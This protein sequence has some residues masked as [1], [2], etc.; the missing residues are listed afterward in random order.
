MKIDRS[1][2]IPLGIM[3]TN[4]KVLIVFNPQAGQAKVLLPAIEL[5]AT[6][7][8]SHGWKVDLEPTQCVNDGIRIAREGAIN[9]YDII[10]AAGGD[11]TVNEVMNGLVHTNC[12]LGV[13]PAGTVNI[14]ARE[15]GLPMDIKQCAQELL[16]SQLSQIDVGRAS[17][18]VPRRG[19]LLSRVRLRK[20]SPTIVDRYFLLMGGIG[21]DAAVTASVNPQEKKYLGAIAYIKRAIQIA[22]GYQG[23]HL[24]IHLDHQ[25]IRGKILMAVV[26]NSQLYGGMIKFTVNALI[27]DG[28]LDVCIFRGTSM[29]KAPLRLFSIVSQTHHRDD[30][31]EYYQT[32]KVQFLSWRK[33][34][35]QLDGDY[36]GTTPMSFEVVPKSLWILVPPKA[37]RSLWN[38]E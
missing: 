37:D 15:M 16:K 7:W 33:I 12:A 21:F 5:A 23:T 14:W 3:P 4:P 38:N 10:V 28:F 30:R 34:P 22:W 9:G 17:T 13:L 32:K 1:D 19:R 35:V 27:N 20:K 11:G 8:R 2:N 18:I 24:N 36:F 25:R 6:I 31:I 26:G 29:L